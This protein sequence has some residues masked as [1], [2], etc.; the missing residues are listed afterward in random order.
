MRT[1][2]LEI[3]PIDKADVEKI[4]GLWADPKVTSSWEAPKIPR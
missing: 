3:R 4:V 2:R 1:E